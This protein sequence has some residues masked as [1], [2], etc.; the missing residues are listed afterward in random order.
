MRIINSVLAR[1]GRQETPNLPA[2]PPP[3]S[4]ADRRELRE[5]QVRFPR[6]WAAFDKM[7]ADYDG[8]DHILVRHRR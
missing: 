4:A 6:K 8:G 7:I 1:L 2:V 3:L 5:A